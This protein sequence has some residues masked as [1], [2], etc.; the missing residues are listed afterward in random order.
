MIDIMTILVSLCGVGR[1]LTYQRNGADYDLVSS[2][3]AYLLMVGGF[4][5]AVWLFGNGESCLL[6]FIGVSLIVYLI[7]KN[8]GN[9]ARLIKR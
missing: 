2:V 8:H 5:L 7:F 3:F 1:I 6:L 4:G 9:I